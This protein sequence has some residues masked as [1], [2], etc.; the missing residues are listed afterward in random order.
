[1]KADIDSTG[2]LT[3]K[4]ET[5][6]EVFALKQWTAAFFDTY[7]ALKPIYPAIPAPVSLIFDGTLGN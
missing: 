4:A 2:R 7:G 1:M 5:E 3:I 6:L